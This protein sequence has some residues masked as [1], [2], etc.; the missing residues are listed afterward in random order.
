MPLNFVKMSS[1]FYVFFSQATQNLWQK[2]LDKRLG[3]LQVFLMWLLPTLFSIP[4][5]FETDAHGNSIE[6]TT[7]NGSENGYSCYP[8]SEGKLTLLTDWQKIHFYATDIFV[9]FIIV[10]STGIV[11]WR[12]RQEIRETRK[13][14]ETD[15]RITIMIQR[16]QQNLNRSSGIIICSYILLRLPWMLF[17]ESN[18]ETFSIGQRISVILYF[19]KFNVLY[20]LFAFTNINYCRA[21]LDFLRL[22]FPCFCSN[23]KT[24]DQ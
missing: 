3:Y 1:L 19:M 8:K 9:L 13:R 10:I 17:P 11:I 14:Q 15:H 2:I 21:Y 20:L 6:F 23:K 12:F 5:W 4:L 18:T 7:G 22:L 24:D 16:M